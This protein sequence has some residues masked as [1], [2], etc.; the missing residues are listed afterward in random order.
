MNRQLRR[1]QKKTGADQTATVS[2][3]IA[4]LLDAGIQNQSA[5]HFEQAAW[6]YQRVLSL[7]PNQPEALCNLGAMLSQ[8]GHFDQGE[9]F[10]KQALVARPHFLEACL[11]LADSH[12]RRGQIEAAIDLLNRNQRHLKASGDYWGLVGICFLQAQ[13]NGD[14]V[15]ALGKAV[16]ISPENVSYKLQLAAAHTHLNNMDD[17]ISLLEAALNQDPANTNA[18]SVLFNIYGRRSIADKII[19]YGNRLLKVEGYKLSGFEYYLMSGAYLNKTDIGESIKFMLKAIE[20]EPKNLDLIKSVISLFSSNHNF[21]EAEYW[22]EKAQQ[23]APGNKAFD[24]ERGVLFVAQQKNH[25]AETLLRSFVDDPIH[26]LDGSSALLN[27]AYDF[28]LM[29]LMNQNKVDDMAVI[30]ERAVQLFPEEASFSQYTSIIHNHKGNLVESGKWALRA[31]ERSSVSEDA[32]FGQIIFS[33]HY[34]SNL[35]PEQIAQTTKAFVQKYMGSIKAQN[36]HANTPDPSRKIKVG[37]VSGDFKNHPVADYITPILQF[38]DRNRFEVYCYAV[39]PDVDAVTQK[40]KSYADHW[41]SLNN[42][43]HDTAASMIVADGID[44]LIDLSGHTRLARLQVFARKP[45]P[46]QATWIGYFNTTGLPTMDYIITDKDLL[47]PEDEPLYTEAPL[48]LPVSSVCYKLPEF[49]I[50]VGPLPAIRN[51]HITFGCFGVHGKH[52]DRA[53]ELW[54]E[55]LRKTPDAKLYFKTAGF[56]REDV[57]QSYRD[58]FAAMGVDPARLRFEGSTPMAHYLAQYNEVDLMLD[59]FPYNAATTCLQ[60]LW[61]GVPQIC[62][63]GNMLVSRIG[64]SYLTK[65]GLTDFV[66]R[67]EAEYVEK[68]VNWASRID[69]LS[70][71]RA[72]LRQ[73]LSNSPMTNPTAFTQSYEAALSDVWRKWCEDQG[74]K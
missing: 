2:A 30:S 34:D 56:E 40:L 59:T 33:M 28:L 39:N 52:S 23:I 9:A 22:L 69:E 61:M 36:A 65:L 14:A 37:Y 27:Q 51:G 49:S 21:E 4:G 5:S 64:D 46:I 60:A 3:E 6:F 11:A 24:V 53:I 62:M 41:R 26:N 47:P 13:K 12:V 19:E 16:A 10:L 73:T 55:I 67:S 70:A 7:N 32:G 74:E 35:G 43:S 58:R 31:L 42:I 25:Q 72:S 48:R 50:K 15:K 66:A 45:A 54:A 8:L 71:I 1:M 17:A 63:R 38:H 68:A 20:L 44:I 18:L 57:R 29:A